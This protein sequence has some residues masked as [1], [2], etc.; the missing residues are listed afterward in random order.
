MVYSLGL[1]DMYID[2]NIVLHADPV[3]SRGMLFALSLRHPREVYLSVRRLV[4]GAW[5]AWGCFPRNDEQRGIV[6]KDTRG[7]RSG[8]K[9]M[10]DEHKQR[11]GIRHCRVDY[12]PFGGVLSIV[13]KGVHGGGEVLIELRSKCFRR[14]LAEQLLRDKQVTQHADQAEHGDDLKYNADTRQVVAYLA[15]IAAFIFFDSGRVFVHD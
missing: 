8:R 2:D 9:F 5:G 7:G 15:E 11:R 10:G 14:G 1:V 13:P 6:Q 12:Q 3:D 4:L